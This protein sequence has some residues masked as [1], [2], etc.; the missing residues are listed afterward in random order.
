MFSIPRYELPAEEH[1]KRSCN[2]VTAG[3][4]FKSSVKDFPEELL[5][6]LDYMVELPDE[7]PM[8]LNPK[9][10]DRLFGA[11]NTV[12]KS[13][14]VAFTSKVV[15][16]HF[17]IPVSMESLLT[18]IENK[19]YRLWKL[20]NRKKQLSMAHPDLEKLKMAFPEDA[21]IQSCKT[22]EEVYE[23]AGEPDG[24]GGSAFAID[25]IIKCLAPHNNELS[26]GYDTRVRSFDKLLA[27]LEKGYPVPL[28][29][30]NSV[31]HNDSNRVGGHY[32]TLFGIKNGKAI[33]VDSSFTETAGV[34]ML[35]VKQL[36]DAVTFA[37][38]SLVFV[39]DLSVC[40]V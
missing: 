13:G 37:N 11:V 5:E 14:C 35:P 9:W 33:V 31:Y 18:E 7:I 17:S 3:D 4:E 1:K 20:K 25:A 30:Q 29:V 12:E 19:G 40:E 34:R 23:V 24:I 10:R 36:L 32:V 2:N 26:I 16:D 8:A 21:E 39:W 28:R 27:N 6:K 15:L 38:P 22:L